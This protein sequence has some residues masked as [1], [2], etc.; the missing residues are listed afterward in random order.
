MLEASECFT[1]A[2]FAKINVTVAKVEKT[3]H[4]IYGNLYENIG[5]A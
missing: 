1:K 3:K 4:R 5:Y 2:E